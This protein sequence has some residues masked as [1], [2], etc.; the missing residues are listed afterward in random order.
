[1][2]GAA[3]N[4]QR[5]SWADVEALSVDGPGQDAFDA[6][7]RLLVVIVAVCR[8]RQ[9]LGSGDAAFKDRD[10]PTGVRS[11]DQER[12]A[13]GPIRMVSS[14]G[15]TPSRGIPATG[16]VAFDVCEVESSISAPPPVKDVDRG[17]TTVYRE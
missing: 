4:A 6:V 17:S 7:D 14:E 9:A 16:D 11:G 3:R 12:T 2:D 13:S 5:L 1:M 15:L 8:R 10:A